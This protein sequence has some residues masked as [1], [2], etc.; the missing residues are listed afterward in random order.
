MPGGI[1]ACLDAELVRR[2]AEHRLELPDEMERGDLHL[3]REVGYRR[4][5]LAY[6]AQQ[7]A[8]P[9][10]PPEAFMSEQHAPV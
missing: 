10:Q 7:V 9:A 2:E 3:A 6:L 1:E 5:G 4:G 8:R